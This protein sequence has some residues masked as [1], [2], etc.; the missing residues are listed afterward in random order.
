MSKKI[1]MQSIIMV[2]F[3]T[4]S[5]SVILIMAFIMYSRWYNGAKEENIQST[6]NIMEQTTNSL[7][8]YLQQ[9]RQ[10]SDTAYYSIIKE[11]DIQDPKMQENLNLLYETNKG[12]LKS[13][14]IFSQ[15]GELLMA[16]PVS[17]EKDNKNVLEQQWYLNA[18]KKV[19]NMHFSL[20]HIQNLF[21]DGTKRMYWVI[22]LSRVVDVTSNEVLRRGILLVDMDYAGISDIIEQVNYL[23][24]NS[25][26]YLCDK[27]GN[28]IYHPKRMQIREGLYPEDNVEV[29]GK[30]NGLYE[31]R[32][33][34]K[35]RTVIIDTIGY[36]G[37]KL[38][39]VINHGGFGLTQQNAFFS[40]IM[41]ISLMVMTMLFISRLVSSRISNPLQMLDNSVLKYEAGEKP[42]IYIGGTSEIRHLS[43]SIRRYYDQIE[44]LMER[45]AKEQN[46]R[47]KSELEALQSQINP[48][49][50][51]NTLDSITWMIESGKNDEAVFMIVQ[52]ARLFRIS[53]SK[54]KTI[55]S[56]KDE[57]QHA[58]SYLNIQKLRYK[59][60]FT[61]EYDVDS[62]VEDYC[63]VKLV[64]QPLLE[65][66]I[67]YGIEGA[68]EAKIIIRA[69][70][71]GE[72]LFIS[73]RDNGTG[74]PSDQAKLV[75]SDSNRIH[76]KGS[77]VGL[78]NVNNRIKILF[79]EEYGLIFES[80]ADE[81]AIATIH[82]PA[83]SYSDENARKLEG[84]DE[85]Q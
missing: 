69:Y 54:G 16:E 36:T 49:F 12:S 85:A 39:A 82:I 83:I 19:E 60:I 50:L 28:F 22:S 51:Y 84:D 47:R 35:K 33:N 74:M 37:W 52:L 31:E 62:E 79:G 5:V 43:E 9:M 26:F 18:L 67:N 29:A 1:S 20:P 48:H 6:K 8:N 65:N 71:E 41:L 63:I 57:L 53:L 24:T 40:V 78:I 61:V 42:D 58:K 4:M 64:L 7:E 23:N 25:Y 72:D 32:I 30:D 11:N 75:L 70:K 66:A 10:I 13:I 14:A 38:V 2:A 15:G 3:A 68:D 80:E 46:E 56:V 81:G 76:K 77:G 34:G 55:I 45:F 44:L 59:D 17:E 73:V 21:E 27:D